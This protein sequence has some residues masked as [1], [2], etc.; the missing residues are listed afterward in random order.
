MLQIATRTAATRLIR[1]H[2]LATGEAFVF[3]AYA[4]PV[5]DLCQANHQRDANQSYNGSPCFGKSQKRVRRATELIEQSMDVLVIAPQHEDLPDA[6]IEIAAIQR[7]HNATV[8]SGIVRESD[9][10]AAVED[11]NVEIIWW[12]THGDKDG[13]LLSDAPLS[14]AG[15]GQ[16]VRASGAALCI[17]NTCS[18]ET[19][20]LAIVATGKAD[21]I[22]T[23]GLVGNRDAIRLGSLL[24]GE[25]ANSDTY[26]EAYQIVAPSGGLYRYLKAGTQYRRRSDT[27]DDDFISELR[28]LMY[29]DKFGR[30]G[31]PERV[32]RLE[33]SHSDLD[34]RVARQATRL[35]VHAA[36]LEEHE[37]RMD[38]WETRIKSF[39]QSKIVVDNR[40]LYLFF[41]IFG[42]IL[43][44]VIYIAIQTT[45]GGKVD[46]QIGSVLRVLSIRLVSWFFLLRLYGLP[47]AATIFV[48]R[49]LMASA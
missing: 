2:C 37:K 8:L 24:A 15:V 29:S 46:G 1:C 41:L 34:S 19:V 25:L 16:Y 5:A 21:M 45:A 4:S 33:T 11:G 23:I 20:A 32:G 31:L 49:M 12:I 27:R 17:L 6:S 42:L 13:V 38:E 44:G 26:Y 47:T 36:R 28:G 30:L 3:L 7:F 9:I 40:T 35:D 43:L 39:S 48:I 14:V 10:T 18:S 22:C